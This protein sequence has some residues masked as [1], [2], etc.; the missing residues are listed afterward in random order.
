K[1][2]KK[3][4]AIMFAFMMVFSLSTNVKAQTDASGNYD[5]GNGKITI[6]NAVIGQNYTI[7]RMLKLESYSG[8]NYSYKLEDGWEDFINGT[9]ADYLTEDN[10]GYI[11]FKPD[12]DTDTGM[13][14]FAQKALAFAKTT[15]LAKDATFNETATS[16]TVNFGNLPLGYYVV[17]STVG[18]LCE[19]TTTDKEVSIQ[20]KNDQPT[21]DKKIVDTSYRDETLVTNNSADIGESVVFKTTIYIK[22]GAKNYVLHDKMDSHL[23]FVQIQRV[24]DNNGKNYVFSNDFV[25]KTT[26]LADDDCTFELSFTDNFYT[27]NKDDIDS[28]N[29][30]EIYIYYVAKVNDDAIVNQAMNNTAKLTYGE[31]KDMESNPSTTTTKTFGIPLFKC[32]KDNTELAGAEFM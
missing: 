13:R 32:T 12:K 28:E 21:V 18:S 26:G 30:N 6:S 20:D 11:T 19:L 29:L 16:N 9:G 22:P 27:S 17:G 25:Y 4:A 1:L 15:H 23:G 14:L 2:I 24:D 8:E 5:D 31:N 7:Y 10:N 3:I